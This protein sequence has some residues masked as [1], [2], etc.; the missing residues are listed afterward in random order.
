LALLLGQRIVQIA[1][2]F[3]TLLA[4]RLCRCLALRRVRGNRRYRYVLL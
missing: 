2:N 3:N 1:L 4:L